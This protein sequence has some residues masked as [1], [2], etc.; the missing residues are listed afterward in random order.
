MPIQIGPIHTHAGYKA[1]EHLQRQIWGLEDA[2]VVPLHLLLTAATNGGVLLAAFDGDQMV[3][4]VFG[5][6]GLTPDGTLKHCSHMAGVLPA[7]RSQQVGYRLKLAQRER[8]RAQGI[9]LVT[10][11][12]D[13]LESR[14]AALNLHKLGATSRK[15]LPDLYGPMHDALNAGLASDRLQVDWVLDSLDVLAR[16]QGAPLPTLP[17]LRAARVAVWNEPPEGS[18]LRPPEKLL[19]MRDDRLLLCIPADIQAIKAADAG[20]AQAWRL[21]IRQLFEEAFA[22]GYVATDLLASGDRSYYLLHTRR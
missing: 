15:Y 18:P 20:L 11:T 5:F 17:E 19:P 21:H 16:L 10:W 6:P 12:F 8:V 7:Y 14:N 22:A 13:P 4:F 9:G 2:E 1:V 3:G